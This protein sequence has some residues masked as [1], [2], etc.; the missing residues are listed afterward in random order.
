MFSFK[1]I[2]MKK[3]FAILTLLFIYNSLFAQIND[4][5]ACLKYH[6]GKFSYTDP[7]GNIVLVD[8]LKNFQFDKNQT[9]KV[10]TQYRIKWINDCQYEL[11]LVSTNSKSLRKNKYSVTSII[12]S[13]PLGDSGYEYTCACKDPDLPKAAGVM[14]KIK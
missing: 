10:K 9:T 14:K 3:L 13:K 1:Y 2:K 8:R 6:R 7:A 12:I 4:S 5:S 11:T